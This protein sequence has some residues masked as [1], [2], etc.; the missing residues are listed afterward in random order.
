MRRRHVW[1]AVASVL[2]SLVAL[3]L[4]SRTSEPSVAP[5][6]F[7][8]DSLTERASTRAELQAPAQVEDRAAE[9]KSTGV[10][11]A[12]HAVLHLTGR[13]HVVNARGEHVPSER[14]SV[15][16]DVLES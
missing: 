9:A 16:W 5:S 2:A 14:G 13:V 1:I 12:E 4:V 3:R 7:V 11:V 10:P 6:P 15:E 8:G